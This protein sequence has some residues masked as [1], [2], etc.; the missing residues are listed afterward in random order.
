MIESG[1]DITTEN[2]LNATNAL[3]LRALRA[4][5]VVDMPHDPVTPSDLPLQAVTQ[6]QTPI[7]HV[8][9][10]VGPVDFPLALKE[11]VTQ[12]CKESRFHDLPEPFCLK[13][14][15][16]RSFDFQLAAVPMPENGKYYLLKHLIFP[17]KVKVE[18][19]Q[20]LCYGQC[21]MLQWQE[22]AKNVKKAF[23]H[24]FEKMGGFQVRAF[25]LQASGVGGGGPQSDEKGNFHQNLT[26]EAIE[27]GFDYIEAHGP[28]THHANTQLKSIAKQFISE[29]SSIKNWPGRPIKEALRNLM[30]LP[31]HDFPL[32]FVDVDPAVLFILE[33]LPYFTDKAL[34]M[35]GIP[36]VGKTPLGRI[37]TMA[38]SR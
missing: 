21:H 26:E 37:I 27:A 4:P 13:V 34:G 3:L 19:A 15:P 23:Q 20:S 29:E 31:V 9:D 14:S 12:I 5:N 2:A 25:A 32:T 28:R 35:H 18:Q 11:Q 24:M 30:S 8:L 22:N 16:G 1:A 6:E 36:N 7:K 17:E 33:K 10:V 38:M